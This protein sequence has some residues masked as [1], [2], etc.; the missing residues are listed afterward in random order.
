MAG[1]PSQLAA[2]FTA[3]PD[4]GTKLVYLRDIL[5]LEHVGEGH[6]AN[7]VPYLKQHTP[8]C[9]PHGAMWDT[10][11]YVAPNGCVA[12]A[13]AAAPR[14]QLTA[15]YLAALLTKELAERCEVLK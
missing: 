10:A 12:A 6:V 2:I 1:L 4:H 3:C 13:P 8:D 14:N 5:N 7:N 11:G 9:V 15:R